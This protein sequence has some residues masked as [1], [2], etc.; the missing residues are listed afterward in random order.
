V[1]GLVLGS[2]LAIALGEKLGP[3]LGEP[4]GAALGPT[5]GSALGARPGAVF[6]PVPG[7]K[8]EPVLS[9][10]DGPALGEVLSVGELVGP[11]VLHPRFLPLVFVGPAICTLVRSY[12]NGLV[13]GTPGPLE[14]NLVVRARV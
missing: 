10:T 9:D 13:L 6:G 5:L 4:L 7:G 3:T 14:G 2:E 12:V 1:L 11:L 8:L